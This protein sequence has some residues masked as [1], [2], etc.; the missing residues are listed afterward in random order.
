MQAEQPFTGTVI[1]ILCLRDV[2]PCKREI[3]RKP[4][5]YCFGDVVHGVEIIH[6]M[7]VEPTPD[8]LA[9]HFYLL[10]PARRPGEARRQALFC[11][12]RIGFRAYQKNRQAPQPSL[13]AL[14][15]AFMAAV[16]PFSE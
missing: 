9:A 7:G 13:Q 5:P 11:P 3:F 6:A 1:G 2:E 15:M 4:R 16:T 14:S 8:L 10:D 12:P